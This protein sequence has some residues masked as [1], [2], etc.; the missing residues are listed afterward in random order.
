MLR[1]A[2]SLP[3]L[4]SCARL[5][6]TT[7]AP[8]SSYAILSYTYCADVME[9]R[10]PHRPAHLALA[11]EMKASDDL[12]MAGATGPLGGADPDGGLFVFRSEE[13][14][15]AFVEKDAYVENGIVTGHEVRAWT[16]VVE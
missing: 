13:A 10:G 5:L 1:H 8:P 14:A 12:L 4:R 11:Q 6:S 2:C 9:K 3:A 7:P 15:R 16:V